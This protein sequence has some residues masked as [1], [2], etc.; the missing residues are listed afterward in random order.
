MYP[1]MAVASLLVLQEIG[2]PR[3]ARVNMT[4]IVL[5]LLMEEQGADEIFKTWRDTELIDEKENPRRALGYWDSWL[6][7]PVK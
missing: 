3:A 7:L 2:C 1:Y 4:P 5:W 6:S